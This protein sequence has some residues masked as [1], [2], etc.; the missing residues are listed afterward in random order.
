MI[1]MKYLAIVL[2]MAA[3]PILFITEAAMALLN[4][5]ANSKMHKQA[6]GKL[7]DGRLVDLYVLTNN[8]GMTATI[9]NYGATLVSLEVPDKNGKPSDITLGYDGVGGYESGK[10]YFGATVGRYGNRIAHGRFVVDGITYTLAKNDGENSV[11]GGALGFNKRVW[12]AKD[13]STRAGQALE[14]IYSSKDGEEGYPGNVAVTVVYTVL[15]EENSL[16]ID[17]TATTDKPTVVNLT[18]HSYFNL[19]GQGNGDI[20]QHQLTI[21]ASRFTPVDVTLIPTGELREVRDSPFDFTKPNAIGARIGQGDQ[22]LIF[23]KGYDHN[24]VMDRSTA[25]SLFL[26]AEVYEPQTGRA[27][28]VSTTEPG[29]QFYS[30]NF[31]DGSIQGKGR[32]TYG[33]RSGLCLETQHFPDSPNRPGFPSSVLRPG[34]KLHSTTVYKFSVK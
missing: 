1:V 18:H 16:R 22:Q 17:Y 31:L 2:A 11:H 20:L 32:K 25:D 4:A 13:V 30:G 7:Q 23:G 8:H 15:S 14:L 26:A 33:H 9:T 24:W 27:M 10:A 29:L 12:A 6:F 34:Q 3:M 28:E 5:E 21:H 19:A